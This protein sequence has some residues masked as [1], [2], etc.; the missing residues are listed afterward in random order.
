MSPGK[1]QIDFIV[2]ITSLTVPNA[3]G[4][5][6]H[7]ECG[8]KVAIVL[9][10]P[11]EKYIQ[12]FIEKPEIFTFSMCSGKNCVHSCVCIQVPLFVAFKI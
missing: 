9:D 3:E 2:G 5:R 7:M 6:C 12:K 10:E 1:T 4:L 11:E 8:D